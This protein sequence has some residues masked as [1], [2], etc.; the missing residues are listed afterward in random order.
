M[1]KVILEK[2]VIGFARETIIHNLGY[3][4]SNTSH[5][6]VRL[7]L[8]QIEEDYR[9]LTYTAKAFNKKGESLK[10]TM[11]NAFEKARSSS[12]DGGV[13]QHGIDA[14]LMENIID[15]IAGVHYSQEYIQEDNIF[16]R[17]FANHNK[18][19]IKN[20]ELFYTGYFQV[21]KNNA[22]Y[23]ELAKRVKIHDNLMSN[24]KND[25]LEYLAQTEKETK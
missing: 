6:D 19:I 14:Y 16:V 2:K 20:I 22:D 1:K 21:F 5:K 24:G 7:W 4:L 8:K 18:D 23:F 25:A 15:M 12:R 17:I 3:C 11:H 9:Q 10:N 13:E